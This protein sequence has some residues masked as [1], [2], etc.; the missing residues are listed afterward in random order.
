[1]QLCD[2]KVNTV[3]P[4]EAF[5]EEHAGRVLYSPRNLY[6]EQGKSS[7]VLMFEG[8]ELQPRQRVVLETTPRVRNVEV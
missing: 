5:P 4:H 6:G 7:P 3:E 1:M 2:T 8:V